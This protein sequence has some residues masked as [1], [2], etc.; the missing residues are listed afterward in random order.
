MTKSLFGEVGGVPVEEI[1]IRSKA[2]AT[3]KILTWGA[4]VR[5]L[6]VPA[7]G[8]RQSVTLGLNTI[9]DYVA[10]SPHFGA[11]PGRFA[12]RIANG[13]FTLDGVEH[14]LDKKPGDKHTLHGG[15]KG[16][17]KRVWTLGR[18]DESSATLT[19]ESPDGDAGFPGALVATCVYR[20]LE[21]TTLRVEFTATTD[22]PTVVNLTQHAYFNLD[23][24][25]DILD[26]EVRLFA[27][28]YTPSDAELIPT[29]EIRTVAASP[30]DFRAARPVR[31]AGGTAYD[32]NFVVAR[33]LGSDG[34]APIAR[35]RSPKNGLTL[36]LFSDQPGV[37]F[38]DA[39]TLNV[40]VPGLGGARYG[41]HAGLCLETQAFPD[42]PN[43]RHFTDTTLRPGAEYRHV[44]EFR[45]A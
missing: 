7:S 4:V 16:F 29:G 39:A 11:V 34:L 14:T 41:A 1:V 15:P 45:F 5:E 28:F 35:V 44:S 8:G 21:P 17:G 9:D 40:P 3:A 13:R 36:S 6:V 23:G 31:N 22:K 43:R 20:L 12:N 27:D 18:Y 2:G 24:S 38:Y 19:I 26:H 37:Q 30:Y 33:P 42:S 10:H 32:T 25:A